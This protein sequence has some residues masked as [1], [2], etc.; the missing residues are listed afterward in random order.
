[1]A[2]AMGEHRKVSGTWSFQK[3]EYFDGHITAISYQR[4]RV[5][6]TP[7][8]Y[9]QPGFS[10]NRIELPESTVTLKLLTTRITYTVTPRMFLSGL[11]QYNS[12][13]GSMSTNIRL[14]WEYQPG[15]ELFVV[16][17]DLRDTSSRRT[18][19]LENHA[20][21]VKLTRLFRL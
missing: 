7:Q 1:V 13:N 16:Y 12:S 11:L 15:S 18:A 19:L 10:I 21:V 9:L 20:F 14:R 8:L 6:L 4:G 5:S 2:Y 3:G 17:N